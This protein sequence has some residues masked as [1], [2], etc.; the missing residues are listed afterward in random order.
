[1]DLD[2]Y[3]DTH[4]L[5]LAS[6]KSL[7]LHLLLGEKEKD[8]NTAESPQECCDVAQCGDSVKQSHRTGAHGLGSATYLLLM[9][10]F[11][12]P[13]HSFLLAGTELGISSWVKSIKRHMDGKCS[14]GLSHSGHSIC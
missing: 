6:G 5:C 12:A 10:L 4:P 9:N 1:M 8:T 11:P 2:P 7:G 3:S 14:E 13:S